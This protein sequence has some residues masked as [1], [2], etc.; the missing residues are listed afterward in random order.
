[1]R[2]IKFR[3]KFNGQW[4]S[5]TSE[6]DEW[7]QFWA[8]IDKTTVGQFTGLTDLNE[9]EIYE[10]DI[11]GSF[12][13]PDYSGPV[14]FG[15]VILDINGGEYDVEMSSFYVETRVEANRTYVT[16]CMNRGQEVVIGN[17]YDNP[18]LIKET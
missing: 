2:V 17:M 5:V 7:E 10:G 6:D 9:K 3:A 15:H 14:C 4:W 12:A 11:I 13:D 16:E 1:M 8:L 18:E